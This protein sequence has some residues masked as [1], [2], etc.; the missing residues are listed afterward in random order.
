M[1]KK[2]TSYRYT[3]QPKN[4]DDIGGF[5]ITAIIGVVLFSA[6]VFIGHES[7][8]SKFKRDAV[9]KNCGYYHKGNFYFITEGPLR[10]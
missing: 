10:R 5:I 4:V 3:S 1:K 9:D 6:G 8:E 2:R 7:T